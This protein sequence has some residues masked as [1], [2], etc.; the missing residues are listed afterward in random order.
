MTTM[1]QTTGGRLAYEVYG[2]SGR[3]IVAV[4]GLGDTRATFRA[5]GPLLAEA[6][7]VLYA[8]DLRGHGD[9][10]AGFDSYTPEDIG[11]DMLALVEALDLHDVVLAG[12]SIGAAAVAHAALQSDRVTG[13]VMLSGFVRDMPADRWF[14]P[15]VPLLLA[16]LW[17]PG[18]WGRQRKTLFV[19][20]PAD[21]DANTDA[22]VANVREP[23]RMAAV[24][25]MIRATKSGVAA[26]LG[27]VTVPTLILMGAQDPDFSDPAVEAQT[28]AEL[29]GGQPVVQMVEAAGHYPQIERPDVVA[30]HIQAFLEQEARLGA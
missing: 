22:L 7:F 26:R 2:E 15:V 1:L 5:L 3:P 6:G 24:R 4:P 8:M 29:L 19:T 11:D 18:L 14:R 12:N 30:R 23:G 20:K 13:L 21:L 10:D 9:S 28:Q 25:G 16:D 27:E 17:G